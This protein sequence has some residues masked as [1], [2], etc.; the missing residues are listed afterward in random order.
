[1]IIGYTTGVFDLFH[2]GHLNILKKSKSQC[3]YLVVGV[4]TDRLA[5]ERKGKKPVIPF[6]ER[7]EIVKNISHVDQVVAQVNMDKLKAW[8][9]IKFHKMFVGSDWKGTDKW[10]NLENKFAKRGVEIVYFPYTENTSSTILRKVL[11]HTLKENH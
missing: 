6:E 8:E 9:E 7:L 10:N 3:D 5:K 4:T 11:Q 2:I 1:M